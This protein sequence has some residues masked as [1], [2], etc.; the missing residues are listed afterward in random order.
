[1]NRTLRAVTSLS[2]GLVVFLA[3]CGSDSPTGV[4]SGDQLTDAEIQALLSE[5]GAVFEQTGGGFTASRHS[6]LAAAPAARITVEEGFDVS[7][8]CQS[9][10]VGVD[11][12]VNG[13]VDDQT[14]EA[15]LAMAF[16]WTFNAC[17]VPA[18]TITIT[19]S[20]EDPSIALD[21]DFL[22]TEEEI[23]LSGTL[24][25]G[26]SFVT[27][28]EREGS[29]SIEITSDASYNSTTQT[30]TSSSSGTVCGVSASRFQTF[31]VGGTT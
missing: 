23:S 28:D 7:V 26:F 14:F 4:N 15:E 6:G 16:N 19:V 29:C 21:M 5:L 24:N 9:G 11:G 30:A 10:S 13:W 25:G 3:A 8:P 18:E 1:M 31:T 12:S 22:L 27:S 20:G 2:L 17:L